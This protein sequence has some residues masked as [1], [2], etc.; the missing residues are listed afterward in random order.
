MSE[1][2]NAQIMEQAKWRSMPAILTVSRR[3][4]MI[5]TSSKA[6]CIRSPFGGREACPATDGSA[7]R[8]VSRSEDRNP[9]NPASG[10]YVVTAR[11]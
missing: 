5:L 11:A 8:C 1:K 9:A 2:E 6:N 10:D 7:C 4:W 3:S